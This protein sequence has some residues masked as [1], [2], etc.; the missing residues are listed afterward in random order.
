VLS[1]KNTSSFIPGTVQDIV[2]IK[3]RPLVLIRADKIKFLPFNPKR[4][5]TL[6]G[7][8][9]ELPN[10]TDAFV[11]GAWLVKKRK[12]QSLISFGNLYKV[13]EPRYRAYFGINAQFKPT[14]GISTV[15]IGAVDLGIL[16]AK[17]GWQEAVMLDSGQSTSLVYKGKSLVN[18]TPRPV[19]HVIG[20][21]E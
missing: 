19:P 21:T 15:N 13:N 7:I 4:H 1:N 10:V 11:S 20:L 9:S 16:L 6:D 17:E 5:N 14:L 2:R 3:G 18:Y 12:A 8:N